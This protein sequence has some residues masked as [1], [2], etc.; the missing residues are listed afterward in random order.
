MCALSW[1]LSAEL[2][3]GGVKEGRG[4]SPAAGMM[5]GGLTAMAGLGG[6]GTMGRSGR[7]DFE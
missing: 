5:G 2:L 1:T 7:A 3:K 6:R 4:F